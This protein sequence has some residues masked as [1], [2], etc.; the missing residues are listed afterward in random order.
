MASFGRRRPYALGQADKTSAGQ[1]LRKTPRVLTAAGEKVTKAQ[2]E[3]YRRLIQPWQARAFAYYDLLG[4]IKFASQ[5]YSRSIANL[6]LFIAKTDDQGESEEVEDEPDIQAY[7][8]RIRDPGGGRSSLLASYGRLMFLTGECMLFVSENEDTGEEQWEMLSTDELKTVQGSYVRLKA[9]SL[10]QQQY[11]VADDDEYEAVSPQAVAYRLW[12]RHPRYSALADSTMQG[13]LE[14]CEELVLLTQAVRAR[15]RSRLA[16]SG[17]LFISEDFGTPP[18]EPA[19]DEDPEEDVFL[20]ALTEAMTAPLL[21]EGTASAVVPLVVR[22]S[23]E[24][25][26]DGVKHV[27]IIDPT[28]LYP[29]TGLR[30]ECIKR[31]AMGLDLPPEI[32]LGV[33]DANHWSAWVVQEETWKAH[34]QPIAQQLVDDLTSAYL[35]PALRAAGVNNWQDYCIDYDAAEIINHPDRTKDAKDLYEAR[36]IGKTALRDAA[37]FEDDDAPTEEELNEMLGVAIRDASLAVYGI[38]AIRGLGGLEPA[39]GEIEQGKS[40]TNPG[41][42]TQAPTSAEAAKGPPPNPAE[43]K[44]Q[45]PAPP[46]NSQVGSMNGEAL[47]AKILGAADLAMHRAREQAGNRLRSLAKRDDECLKLLDG[48]RA[49]QVAPTLGVERVRALR[50]PHELQLVEGAAS[51]L[52]DALKLWGI[53]DA[54]IAELLGER[55]EQHAART[56]YEEHPQPLPTTF[57]HYLT[58]LRADH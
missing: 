31:I 30:A 56:L 48:V 45:A 42:I 36:A 43:A 41:G 51:L 49:G 9:P 25:I 8:E 55:I 27:Q 32:L 50:A 38:P 24:A 6:R 7:L 28:Q 17:I 3:S 58:G 19:P 46:V 4:E 16:G 37:G 15:A 39:P 2:I 33:T 40:A 23:T 53:E 21:D 26:K 29:E 34:L 44:G 47:T 14:I 10:M 13:V 1:K 35:R 5:F 12:R 22:G 11:Q 54:N 18:L 57:Q 52:A 20:E